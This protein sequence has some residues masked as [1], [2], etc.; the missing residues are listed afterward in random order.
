MDGEEFEVPP[1][2][3]FQ[4]GLVEYRTGGEEHGPCGPQT[5]LAT[6]M[7]RRE[8]AGGRQ[9]VRVFMPASLP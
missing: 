6:T 7:P 4:R 3:I 9:T 8:L 2:Q 1:P 5:W